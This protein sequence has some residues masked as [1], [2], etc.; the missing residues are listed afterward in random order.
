MKTPNNILAIQHPEL[1]KEW[2]PTKNNDLTPHDVTTGSNKK[3]WW[4]CN[5]NPEH[6]WQSVIFQ[7]SRGVGCP[8]CAGKKVDHNN[9]LATTNPK[10]ASE[11]HPVKNGIL[12][13]N[14]VTGKSNKKAWWRCGNNPNHEW[15]AHI[16]NRNTG[17]GC[18]YCAN[19]RTTPETSL[20]VTHPKLASEWHP[21]KNG[22]LTPNDVSHGSNKTVCWLNPE[23]FEWEEMIVRRAR[24]K[25]FTFSKEGGM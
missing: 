21:T 20:Q 17:N 18:P 2:H 7:R 23:G 11:W 5:Q 22:T 9:S 3:V 25:N 19:I 16:S 6:E 10:L 24:K 12:T 8:F 14:D 15:Q 13:A 4:R 1:V